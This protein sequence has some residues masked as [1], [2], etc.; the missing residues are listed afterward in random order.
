MMA[1]VFALS[2]TASAA[3]AQGDPAKGK[4]VY[5]TNCSGCHVLTG[6]GFAG[7]PLA[8]VVGRKAASA[9]GY[10]YSEALT[11]SG[12]VWDD[13][14]LLAFLT[15]PSKLVPGTTMYFNVASPQERDDVIAYLKSLPAP[16]AH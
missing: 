3:M 11:K 1:A 10:T 15:D 16:A 2:L 7:P 9:P 12:I 14:S 13:S 5:D 4:D 6:Q 8:G